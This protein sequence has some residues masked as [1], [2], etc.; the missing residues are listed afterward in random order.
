MSRVSVLKFSMWLFYILHTQKLEIRKP[1]SPP[2]LA[3]ILSSLHF[4]ILHTQNFE[5]L[6]PQVF[7][8][9]ACLGMVNR[10]SGILFLRTQNFGILTTCYCGIS[11]AILGISLRFH[12]F[13][14]LRTQ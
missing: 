8:W 7:H 9:S 3:S 4:E 14:V 5:E 11:L 12:T 13:R 10:W 6:N 2:K 1:S